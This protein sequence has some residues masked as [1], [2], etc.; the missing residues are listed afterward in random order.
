MTTRRWIIGL[1]IAVLLLVPLTAGGQELHGT[2]WQVDNSP[3]PAF[4]ITSL[5]GTTL[6]AIVITFDVDGF[7]FW[8]A[9]VGTL[10]GNTATGPLIFPFNFLFFDV[11]ATATV[12]FTGNQGSFTTF[13]AEDF[14][15]ITSGTFHRVFP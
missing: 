5:A 1:G 14:L 2:I 9:S 10:S 7:P 15:L 4:F 6:V 3:V 8:F 13:G 12:V 11:G